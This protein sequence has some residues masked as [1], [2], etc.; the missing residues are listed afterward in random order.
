MLL[1]CLSKAHGQTTL[2]SARAMLGTALCGHDSCCMLDLQV[3]TW[4]QD[5]L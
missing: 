3:M 4:P 5:C 1:F 2:Q